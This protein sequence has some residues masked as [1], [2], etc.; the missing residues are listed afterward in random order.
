VSCLLLRLSQA[1]VT[2]A[3]SCQSQVADEFECQKFLEPTAK[4]G[5]LPPSMCPVSEWAGAE[6]LEKALAVPA[7]APG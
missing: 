4:Q 5:L 3:I 7:G 2:A 1:V 6:I